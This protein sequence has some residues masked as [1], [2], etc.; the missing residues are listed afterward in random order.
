MTDASE[1]AYKLVTAE[2]LA[3]LR[4]AGS[5]A[6]TLDQADGFIHMSPASVVR[7]TARL[8]YAGNTGLFL[9]RVSLS[10]LPSPVRWDFVAS[11]GVAFPHL[12]GSELPLSAV[13]DVIHVPL[14]ASGDFELPSTI[15]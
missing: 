12:Y 7:E 8:Y 1:Y 3:L 9:L 5:F 13:V 14:S 4:S 10:L 6:S 2:E 15:P 11:R